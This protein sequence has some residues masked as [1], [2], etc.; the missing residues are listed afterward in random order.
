M[1]LILSRY[2][3]GEGRNRAADPREN[4]PRY[5]DRHLADSPGAINGLR[6]RTP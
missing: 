3:H 5:D 2:R 6:R 1:L 4:V